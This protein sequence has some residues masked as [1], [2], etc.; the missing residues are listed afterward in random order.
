MTPWQTALRRDV[1]AAEMALPQLAPVTKR[2]SSESSKLPQIAALEVL[3]NVVEHG[4]VA[5]KWLQQKSTQKFSSRRMRVA[6][7]VALGEKRFV[8]ILQV[9]GKQLLIGSAAGQISLLAVLDEQQSAWPA[10][11]S[12]ERHA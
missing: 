5:C 1:S 12:Q 2:R 6:E 10:G 4:L 11:S 7:T 8:S 9:D 3:R